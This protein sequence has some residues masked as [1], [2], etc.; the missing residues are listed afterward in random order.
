[1]SKQKRNTLPSADNQEDM[2]TMIFFLEIHDT[3]SSKEFSCG[4][5]IRH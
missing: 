2:L 5:R 3:L 4:Q 1:M